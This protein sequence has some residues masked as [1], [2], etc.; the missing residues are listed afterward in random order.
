MLFSACKKSSTDPAP[1]EAFGY[2]AI[3][4]TK[5]TFTEAG[6]STFNG[7]Y[8]LFGKQAP[9]DTL[10]EYLT[11]FFSQRPS[12]GVFNIVAFVGYLPGSGRVSLQLIRYPR[13]GSPVT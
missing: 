12:E 8:Q 2:Y 13:N 5:F 10:Q 1:G 3:D 4:T 11:A 6:A 7:G 9:G